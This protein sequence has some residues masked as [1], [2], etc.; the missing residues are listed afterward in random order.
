MSTGSVLLVGFAAAL[1]GCVDAAGKFGEYEDRVGTVDAST[2]DRPPSMIYDITGRFLLVVD[3]AFVPA[4][5]PTTFV[6]FLTTYTLTERPDGAVTV[7]ASMQPLRVYQDGDRTEVGAPLTATSLSVSSE[8]AFSGVFA[9]RLPGP[10]N[11]LTGAE[12]PIDSTIVAVMQSTD[13]VCGNVTGTVAGL[14]L[15]GSTFAAI[16]ITDPGP[17]PALPALA[18]LT[19]ACPTPAGP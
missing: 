14:D 13:V 12:Q 7:D 19:F 11:P 3:P 17:M 5:D 6:Q 8:G 4:S 18:D 9:G 2:V 10:A 1:V 15:A 16:R